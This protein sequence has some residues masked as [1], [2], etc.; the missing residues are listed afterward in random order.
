MSSKS[1]KTFF[2]NYFSAETIRKNQS[3]VIWFLLKVS[4]LKKGQLINILKA[5]HS[6]FGTSGKN[7]ITLDW[8]F[9][10]IPCKVIQTKYYF[11][12]FLSKTIQGWAEVSDRFS[13]RCGI[14]LVHATSIK[15]KTLDYQRV[16]CLFWKFEAFIF[17]QNW[18]MIKNRI[19][20]LFP[21]IEYSTLNFF[22]E[23]KMFFN[24]QLLNFIQN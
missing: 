9:L 18:F 1:E 11:R 24:K 13:N 19:D 10:I 7:Q 16:L 15:L 23:N 21:K 14:K 12:T 4:Q 6:A 22:R 3:R 2:L 20:F 8:F 17:K 5:R